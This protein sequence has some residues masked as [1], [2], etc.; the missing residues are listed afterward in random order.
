[1]NNRL[2]VVAHDEHDGLCEVD[3]INDDD[4]STIL[5]ILE[6][7]NCSEESLSKNR[8]TLGSSNKDYIVFLDGKL[9][10]HDQMTPDIVDIDDSEENYTKGTKTLFVEADRYVI[11]NEKNGELESLTEVDIENIKRNTGCILRNDITGFADYPS[12]VIRIR[13]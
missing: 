12:D 4:E 8:L 1:M 7:L 3:I 5:E 6:L 11:C 10:E 13:V 9:D 2:I